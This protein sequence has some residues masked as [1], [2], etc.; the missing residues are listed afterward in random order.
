[1]TEW[2]KCS[3]KMPDCEKVLAIYKSDPEAIYNM[4]AVG[5]FRDTIYSC[6]IINFGNK[7]RFIIESHGPELPATH[8]M[9]LP[10]LPKDD[11]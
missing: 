6:R 8:W 2:T 11:Q 7:D 10:E 3:D 5:Y 4:R 9:P 1:M